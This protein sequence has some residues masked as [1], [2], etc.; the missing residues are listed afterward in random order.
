MKLWVCCGHGAGDPGACGN[1]C[2]EAER[3]RAL[4]S[5]IKRRGGDS[6][7]LMD[8]SRNWYADRG[9]DTLAVPEGDAVVELHMDAAS[10]GARGGH[11]IYRAGLAPDAYDRALADG[12]ASM[13]PGR[14]ERLSARSDLRNCNVCAQRG[15]N[16]RLVE[17]GFVT[18]ASDVATFNASLGDLADLYLRA[19]GI[20]PEAGPEPEPEPERPRVEVPEV[21]RGVHRLHN[22][23]NGDHLFTASRAEAE[24]VAN[25]SGWDYE[26]VAFLAGDGAPVQRLY[27]PRS[28]LHMLTASVDEHND[29]VADGWLCEGEAFRQGSS[30]EVRR[31]YD[32]RSGNHMFTSSPDEAASLLG[33]GWSDE[34]VLC[35]VD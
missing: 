35:M 7:V 29:L 34:G 3:V 1:G 23:A 4:G 5:E 24:A 31:L 25:G 18:S 21:G 11:V 32:A 17:N 27:D 26:G 8:T 19:F 15:I 28:G 30:T 2:S 14:S 20:S 10:A 22:P 6:V 9:F 16:Y 33:A 12:V 13:F